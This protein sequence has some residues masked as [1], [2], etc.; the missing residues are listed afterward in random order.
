MK[1]LA[2]SIYRRAKFFRRNAAKI[3]KG[4]NLPLHEKY[5]AYAG[6]NR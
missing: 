3:V 5:S 6:T 4:F 1:N 2:V